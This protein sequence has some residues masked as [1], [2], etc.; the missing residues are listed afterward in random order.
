MYEPRSHA[1]VKYKK[2]RKRV[3][4]ACGLVEETETH[5]LVRLLLLLLLLLLGGGGVGVGSTAG[6]GAGSGGGSTTARA[7][8]GEQVLDVLA[9]QSLRNP[10]SVTE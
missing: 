2:S 1:V 9:I 7:D 6:S 10:E 4:V 8:V 3:V 5:V